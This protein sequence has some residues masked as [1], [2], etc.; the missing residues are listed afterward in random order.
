M[1]HPLEPI[2]ALQKK[3]RKLI[4][5]MR[6][7]RDIPQRQ[8][9]IEAQ[10]DGAR[11]KLE[12]ANDSRKHTE[13][14]LKDIELEIDACRE[15]VNRYKNQQMEAKT[16]DQYRAFVK[17]IGM[18]E[19]EIKELEDK[20]IRL[21]ENLEQG[22]AIVEECEARLNTE[23]EGIADELA[24]LSDRSEALNERMEGL[25]DDR[26]R[27]A[28]LC[29]RVL[30]QKYTRILNNKRDFAVVMVES[31]GHCGGCH[32]KLPP[33]VIHDARNPTKIVSCNFCGRIV[34]NPAP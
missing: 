24:E 5:I 10:L 29:D 20:E 9:D 21:M 28:E 6:E 3:D 32:M 34:Y 30:L 2:V 11:K 14:M 23:K 33:Q 22:K 17:E 25:K 4:R 15:K 27:A 12:M 19:A 8:S 13:A 1:T 18:V 7:I 16:N 31:G 26:R